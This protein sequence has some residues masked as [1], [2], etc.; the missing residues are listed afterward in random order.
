MAR[1]YK[2]YADTS[3]YSLNNSECIGDFVY[4]LFLT[5]ERKAVVLLRAQ[6]TDQIYL[7]Y[8]YREELYTQCL[9][10][11]RCGVM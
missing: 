1:D 4:F 11:V 8:L 10:F 7:C 9:Q 6:E 5:T 2:R 3:L